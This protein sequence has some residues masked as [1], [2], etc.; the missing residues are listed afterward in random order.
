MKNLILK[1]R[2]RNLKALN[3]AMENALSFA[4]GELQQAEWRLHEAQQELQRHRDTEPRRRRAATTRQQ[5]RR[6]NRG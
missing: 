3:M 4:H 5:R 6:Q 1:K 2:L